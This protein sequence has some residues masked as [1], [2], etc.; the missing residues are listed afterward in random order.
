MEKTL[1]QGVMLLSVEQACGVQ[2]TREEVCNAMN[3]QRNGISPGIDH[4]SSHTEV[5]QGKCF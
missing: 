1:K 5:W 3:T 4:Y 2:V